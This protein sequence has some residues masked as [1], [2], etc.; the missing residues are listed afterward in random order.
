MFYQF[1]VFLLS[2]LCVF[3]IIMLYKQTTRLRSTERKLE[4]SDAL[5]KRTAE[6]I[7]ENEKLKK[8]MDSNQKYNETVLSQVENI[9]NTHPNWGFGSE[10]PFPGATVVKVDPI[11]TND[12][13]LVVIKAK[14]EYESNVAARILAEPDPRKRYSIALRSLQLQGVMDRISKVLINSTAIQYT[15]GMETDKDGKTSLY[16]YYQIA[17]KTYTDS[18]M[19]DLSKAGDEASA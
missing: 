7:A 15:L 9:V 13:H 10:C 16:I 8:L 11:I 6:I 14:T 5:A 4:V 3:L 12:E 2:V 17:A 18:Q 19:I 1:M